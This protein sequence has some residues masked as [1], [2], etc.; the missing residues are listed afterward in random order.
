MKVSE[1]AAALGRFAPPAA[2]CDWD[3]VGLLVGRADRET[4]TVYVALDATQEAAETA[5]ACGAGLIVT[6]H[7]VIF[8]GIKSVNDRDAEGRLLL[9]LI[10][11]DISVY[12]MHTN[13]D[14]C[15]GGMADLVA[16]RLG[17]RK[18]APL[19]ETGYRRDTE[20]DPEG[21]A[22]FGIG[23]TAELPEAVSCESLARLVKERF[24]LPFAGY[25]DAGRAVRR[26]AVCPGS[27]RGEFQAVLRSGA[28]CFL[29]GDMGHHEGLDYTAA[30]VS[31]IDAG[32]YGLEH[33]FVD[34]AADY[35]R[36]M[37][38]DLTVRTAPRRFPEQIV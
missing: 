9:Y 20:E 34:W 13:F 30:G 29:T 27:G 22:A 21:A 38:P 31:L 35:L 15:P 14:S 17:L 26:L 23:F 37:F 33:V 28:D 10:Q 18:L 8:R 24:G 3:N 7:P 32:H 36:L 19:E 6:H 1:I 5:A 2:A 11:N 16:E 4:E 25:F 12:S